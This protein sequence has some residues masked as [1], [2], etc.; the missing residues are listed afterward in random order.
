MR[1][2][3]ISKRDLGSSARNCP[4]VSRGSRRRKAATILS[5]PIDRDQYYTREDVSARFYRTFKKHFDPGLYLMVEPSAGTGSFLKLLPDGSVGYDVDPQYPGII[6]DDFLNVEIK[7]H[8]PVAIIGN[9]PFGKNASMAVKFFN[10]AARQSNVIALIL[11]RSFRKASIQNRLD[12]AFHLIFD[13]TVPD[14]AFLFEGKPFNVPATFQIW[15]RRS[16]LR[17]LRNVE[18]QHPDF[19]F[20]TAD[21]AHFAIQ[22]VG[23][24][25]G[26]LHHDFGA[27]P[28]SH[29]FI[30]DKVGKAM[31]QL[32]LR[33]V[34]GD[35]AGNPSLAK[36]KIVYGKVEEAMA[37]LDFRSVTGNVAGN[38]SLA[39][40]EIVSLYRE[41]TEL[42]AAA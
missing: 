4:N 41:W 40:S 34:T 11:P 38:P 29:Y 21:K 5:S 23:A 2:I 8:R 37:Q 27:S 30:R 3:N 33:S 42:R 28:S 9:P 22:R 15:E 25:A 1:K 17:R 13:E 20:T 7:S 18:V 19:E 31:A 10:H 35:V 14:D 24:R 39:K 36:S 16:V 26:R 32:N 12:Q 6:P